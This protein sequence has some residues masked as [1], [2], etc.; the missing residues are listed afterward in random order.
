MEFTTRRWADRSLRKHAVALLALGIA[1]DEASRESIRNGIGAERRPRFNRKLH[2]YLTSVLWSEAARE[3]QK[4]IPNSAVCLHEPHDWT[5]LIIG[6]NHV[7]LEREDRPPRSSRKAALRHQM[8]DAVLP[9]F[10]HLQPTV[11][12]CLMT[13]SDVTGG[14]S[15]MLVKAR[16]GSS[17]L[18]SPIR[19][20]RSEGARLLTSWRRRNVPF[21]AEM[22]SW[23]LLHTEAVT[24][25]ST[26]AEVEAIRP[27]GAPMEP[28]VRPGWRATAKDR[29]ANDQ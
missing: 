27:S 4:L 29:A 1:A 21:L 19:V 8:S 3:W 14:P 25:P 17:T 9:H 5:E 12:S 10:P 11:I 24:F 20:P 13:Y 26:K 6:P 16:L 28:L 18:W 2:G 7:L 22:D 15:A 23:A